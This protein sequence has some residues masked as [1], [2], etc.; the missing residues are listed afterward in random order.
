MSGVPAAPA[1]PTL[2]L[3]VGKGLRRGEYFVTWTVWRDFLHDETLGV[4]D[5]LPEM[6]LMEGL[7]RGPPWCRPPVSSYWLAEIMKST[8]AATSSSVNAELPPLAGMKPLCPW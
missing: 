4:T 6:R 2:T 7:N 3:R 1:L 8:A 5:D